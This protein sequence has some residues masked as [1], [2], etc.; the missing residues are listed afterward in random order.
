VGGD[1]SPVAGDQ[2]LVAGDNSP[3]NMT[4]PIARTFISEKLLAGGSVYE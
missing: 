4:E 1:Q 2:S 3:L